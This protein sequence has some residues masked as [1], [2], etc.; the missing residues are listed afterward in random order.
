[1]LSYYAA[2]PSYSRP[3]SRSNK[4]RIRRV[5]HGLR[6]VAHCD[7]D[8]PR[9]SHGIGARL[10]FSV[11]WS[12]TKAQTSWARS[13]VWTPSG[14]RLCHDNLS[15]VTKLRKIGQN[16]RGACHPSQQIEGPVVG[17][18]AGIDRS[19][20]IGNADRQQVTRYGV[21]LSVPIMDGVPAKFSGASWLTAR[22]GGHY[23]TIGI[24]LQYRWFD[25]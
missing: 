5:E 14:L 25:Q 2:G 6:Y 17:E 23:D 9:S 20:G 22:N 8:A 13:K 18:N 3:I 12:S 1:M 10:R 16:D 15:E 11:C 7:A 19:L 21:T 4:R 24:A